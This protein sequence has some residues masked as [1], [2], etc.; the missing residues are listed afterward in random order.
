LALAAA[1]AASQPALADSKSS[2]EFAL[3]CLA[4]MKGFIAALA[5]AVAILVGPIGIRPTM[6]QSVTTATR[7]EILPDLP[8]VGEVVPG[9]EASSWFGISAPKNTPPGDWDELASSR[10]CKPRYSTSKYGQILTF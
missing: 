9:Y 4:A 2:T 8:T 6:A 1:L 5:V 3:T 7:A 10:F